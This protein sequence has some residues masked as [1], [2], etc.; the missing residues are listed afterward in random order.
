MDLG[1]VAERT[2]E[3]L[4]EGYVHG[5]VAAF[6]ELFERYQGRI[7]GFFLRRTRSRERAEDLYQELFLRIHRARASYDPERRFS[8]WLFQIARRLLIDDLRRS[9]ARPE[10]PVAEDG[11]HAAE[12]SLEPERIAATRERLGGVFDRL[13][14]VEQRV[15]VGSKL[16]GRAYAELARELG[17]S[18]VAIKKLASRAMQRLRLEESDA[19]ASR[20]SV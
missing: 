11:M 8:P 12:P 16:E 4:M 9:A 3:E 5:D 2:D 17:K 19:L 13:S 18:V 6:D 10:I 15:L 1:D 14:D 7:Y 20:A